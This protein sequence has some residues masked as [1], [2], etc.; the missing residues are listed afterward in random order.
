[1]R[2]HARL[3][4]PVPV[5]GHSRFHSHF[6]ECAVVIVVKQQAW[7]GIARHKNVWPSIIVEIPGQGCE[8]IKCIRFRHSRLVAR[9]CESAV[10]IVVEQLAMRSFQSPRAAHDRDSLPDAIITAA[11]HRSIR[12]IQVHVLGD[13]QIQFSVAVIIHERT[14]CLPSN[15]VMPQSRFLCQIR[16]GPVAVVVQEDT[17]PA[18]T[19]PDGRWT[20]SSSADQRSCLSEPYR[21]RDA[22]EPHL[23]WARAC[24]CHHDS[25]CDDFDYAMPTVRR[26][27]S[28]MNR[29]HS[30]N[31]SL[32]SSSSPRKADSVKRFET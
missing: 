20:W 12:K 8:A 23:W 5:E 7:R 30:A 3:F 18:S 25:P 24:V 29:C 2:P 22:P 27:A 1:M 6:L 31:A 16:K 15:V 4:A 26:T 28:V 10:S 17:V 14:T 32:L 9:V 21:W 11:R 13:E 19:S